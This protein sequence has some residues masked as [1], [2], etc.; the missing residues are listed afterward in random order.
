[1]NSSLNNNFTCKKTNRQTQI[2]E[3]FKIQPNYLNPRITDEDTLMP[4]TII[5]LTPAQLKLREHESKASIKHL[6]PIHA[7][8]FNHYDI[9]EKWTKGKCKNC[10]KTLTICVKTQSCKECIIAFKRNPFLL[11]DRPL[12]E[13][14]IENKKKDEIR[15][16]F[17]LWFNSILE[18]HDYKY[19]EIRQIDINSYIDAWND[20]FNADMKDEFINYVDDQLR[21]Q[22]DGDYSFGLD[23]DYK[24]NI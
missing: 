19:F 21:L 7:K 1:M 22:F 11:N 2:F 6:L 20:N 18:D 23:D 14:E 16:Y 13:L 5:K 9:N 12:Y 15:C 10:R 17:P 8:Y 4:G 3:F 24:I